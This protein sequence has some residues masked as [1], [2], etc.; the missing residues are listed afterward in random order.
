MKRT[1]TTLTMLALAVAGCSQEPQTAEDLGKEFVDLVEEAA[2]GDVTAEEFAARMDALVEEAKEEIGSPP[3]APAAD[4]SIGI[5]EEEG[6]SEEAFRQLG[7]SA[8]EFYAKWFEMLNEGLT[9]EYERAQ[10]ATRS[11]EFNAGSNAERALPPSNARAGNATVIASDPLDRNEPSPR[12]EA[13][14]TDSAFFTLGSHLDDVLRI[15]G[16]PSSINQ[17]SDHEVWWY[18]VSTIDISLRDGRVR[19]WSNISG[20]LKVRLDAG[21]NVTDAQTFTRGSHQDDVLRIQGTPSSINR[22]SDHEVWWYGVS[23]IDISLRDGRVT[24]W[25]NIRGNLKV[26]LDAGP[27]VT[28]TQTFTRGSHLDDV[29]RIQGTPSSI[30][31]LSDHEVWWYGVSTIDISLRDGRVTE[32]NN[33]RGNLKVRLDAGPNVTDTQ[34]FTRGSQGEGVFDVGGDV[35][36]P[37]LL[38]QVLPEGSQ[39]EEVFQIGELTDPPTILFKVDPQYSEEARK[40]QYQGTVVLEAIVRS[41]GTVEILRVVRSLGFGLDD[42]AIEAVRQWRFR[43]G[44]R[45]GEPVDVTLTIEVNFN[46]R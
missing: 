1:L 32:W 40:A 25:N 18:G 22:L 19:E 14:V 13:N 33:I 7:N 43:P 23:T 34:T 38:T 28:D 39:G 27:N 31:R 2:V 21:P 16:T 26:R 45:N 30:N 17:Y 29:L 35:T 3:Q 6:I 8:L 41:D 36:P 44:T 12:P 11:P 37:T 9:E 15:Q 5:A 20:N 10:A 42:K 46:L 4:P 24:E